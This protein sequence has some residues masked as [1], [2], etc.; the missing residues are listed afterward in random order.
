MHHITAY[1]GHKSRAPFNQAILQSPA[2]VP[3]ATS[4]AQEATFQAILQYATRAINSSVT[5]VSELRKLSS[6]Q[7]HVVNTAAQALAPFGLFAVGPAID[8]TFVP[9]LPGELL[10]A[11]RFH[12]SIKI[13]VGHNAKEG[14]LFTNPFINNETTFEARVKLMFPGAKESVIKEVTKTLYPPLF[15]GSNGYSTQFE[16]SALVNSEAFFSC[17]T[18]YLNLAYGNNT[19]GK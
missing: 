8:G 16:R 14:D 10:L 6:K 5:S 3:V 2:F 4:A 18:R 7:I 9:K 12:K 17:N 1:G 13:M 19:H 15:N 11:G